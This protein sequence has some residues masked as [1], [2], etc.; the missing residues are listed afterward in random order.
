MYCATKRYNFAMSAC[1][2][3]A[4]GDRLDVLTVTPAS[5]K[6]GMNPG[7]GVYTVQPE[8]HA[9]SVID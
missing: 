4:Y 7:T 9:K 2:Q 3:D 5:V 1:M 8:E 6:S